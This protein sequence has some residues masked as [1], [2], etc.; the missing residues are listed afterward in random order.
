MNKK[1]VVI[2]MLLALISAGAFACEITVTPDKQSYR[3]GDSAQLTIRI[4]EDHAHCLYEGV[5]PGI[6]VRGLAFISKS[7]Y[8]RDTS[9]IW[10]ITY[11]VKITADD[12]ALMAYRTC[13]KGGDSTVYEIPF[14]AA[15][16]NR[17]KTR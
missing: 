5:E 6:K 9:G 17:D 11:T 1:I 14:A 2:L 10:Q 3:L 16:K 8:T 7:T 13:S 12:A 15:E 4:V